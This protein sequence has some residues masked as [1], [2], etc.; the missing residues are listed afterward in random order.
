MAGFEQGVKRLKKC[1][2]IGVGRTEG[3]RNERDICTGGAEFVIRT[4]WN[5]AWSNVFKTGFAFPVQ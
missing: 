5:F 3:E 1:G 2:S 4:C